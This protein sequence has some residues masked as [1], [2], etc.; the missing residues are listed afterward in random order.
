MT[1]NS[2]GDGKQLY[3]FLQKILKEDSWNCSFSC[4]L[5][6]KDKLNLD[7]IYSLTEEIALIQHE[8]FRKAI[9]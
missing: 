5:S 4:F 7:D 3:K 9:E 8:Y 1:V 2:C 6:Q